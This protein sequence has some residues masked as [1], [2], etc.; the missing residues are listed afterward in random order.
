MGFFALSNVSS[1]LEIPDTFCKICPDWFCNNTY[2]FA[3]K[4]PFN[5][6]FNQFN[7]NFTMNLY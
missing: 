3:L 4:G 1:G 2:C 7:T 5:T 6:F